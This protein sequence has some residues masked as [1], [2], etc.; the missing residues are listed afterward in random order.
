MQWCLHAV[1][2]SDFLRTRQAQASLQTKLEDRDDV[3]WHSTSHSLCGWNHVH[4]GAYVR[5]G[6]VLDVA[7]EL[8]E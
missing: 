3:L 6:R 7:H 1:V 8:E 2:D 4:S 5:Y